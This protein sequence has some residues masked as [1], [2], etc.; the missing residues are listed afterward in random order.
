MRGS[1]AGEEWRRKS[2]DGRGS[3]PIA[4]PRREHR[5][6]RDR[7]FPDRE[8]INSPGIGNAGIEG[9]RGQPRGIDRLDGR[10]V[11]A[12]QVASNWCGIEQT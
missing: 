4:E 9:A 2:D 11:D 12:L 10:A 7:G 3:E 8:D 5:S 6:H 1:H